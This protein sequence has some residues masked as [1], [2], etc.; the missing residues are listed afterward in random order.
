MVVVPCFCGLYIY[1][2]CE[3][4]IG[5]LQ[6]QQAASEFRTLEEVYYMVMGIQYP[7]T[8]LLI[9]EYQWQITGIGT[10]ATI[11]TLLR[12]EVVNLRF[13]SWTASRTYPAFVDAAW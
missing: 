6:V 5:A 12:R 7:L 3:S 2:V 4:T 8:P 10:P 1:E 13:S 9:T 11:S